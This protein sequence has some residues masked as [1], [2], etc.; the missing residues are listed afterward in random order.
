[1][2]SEEKLVDYLR[3]VTT[4]LHETRR[5]LRE[6]EERDAEPVAV[7]AMAC[8]FPGGVRSP[9]E[10]WSLVASGGD[11]IGEFPANRGW[12]TGRLFH[13]D[14]GHPGTSIAR[15]GG[16]LEDA[17]LFDSEFFGIS[18]REALTL[19]PQQRQL[20]EVSW[21]LLERAGIDPASL[22]GSRTGVYA[23][24]A[25]P[26]FGT[27]HID[28]SAEGYLITGNAPSVLS[29]RVAY[30]L[31]L[32]GPAVTIDTA[33][34]SSLV[35]IHLA[36]H[37]L[38][39]NECTLALAG[40]VTVMALPNVFTEFSRQRG[41]APDGR[42]KAFAAAADGTGFS[43]GVGLVLLERLSDARRG[44]HDVLALIR[45][46]AINS[47]GA[48]NGLTAPN[49][50]SQQR[51]IRQALESARLSAADVDAV[52]A[53]G[54]GTRL[55]DPIEA[56]ALLA[57]YGR[58]REDDHPL[59]LGTVKSNLGHTQGA[60]GVA[61]LLKMVMALRHELLPATL[62]VDRPTPDVDWDSGAV[63]LL[64]E[65]VP[66]PS[67][68][69]PRRAAVSSFGIS[70]TNA[71]LI[72]EEPPCPEP[73]PGPERVP[74]AAGGVAWPLSART[75]QALTAQAEALA[76]HLAAHPEAA[77]TD[78]SWSL[79]R[80]RT[81]FEHRAVL[82]G[83]DREELCAALT[84][85][86]AGARRHPGLT[87][88]TGPVRDGD[89]VFLFTG[90][91]SQRSGM[92]QELYREYPAFAEAFDEVCAHLDP[93]LGRSLRDLVFGADTVGELGQ[94]AVTQAALFALE[95]AL[96]RLATSAGLVPGYLTGHSVGE[97]TA[98]HAA[99]V[100]SLPDACT[101]VAARGSLMQALPRGGAMVAVQA[102][103]CDVLP[104]LAGREDR[105]SLAAVN[106]PAAVVVSGVEH[107]VEEIAARLRNMGHKARRLR[108]SHAF[109]SPLL[110]PML[111]EFGEVA[112]GLSY[113][114]PRI[115]VISNL[116][117][118]VAGLEQLGDPGYWVRHV[119]Q[120]VR[121]ADGLCTLHAAG[122]IRYL[123]LG[124]APVLTA[125][126]RECLAAEEPAPDAGVF[127][128]VLRENH[129]ETRTFLR[130]LAS[131][132]VDGAMV[133]FAATLPPGARAVPLP[134]YRFQRRH[135]WR[136]IAD[137]AVVNAAGVRAADHP[138]LAAAIESAT[139]ELLF[140]GHLSV[141]AH[142]WL[143]DHDIAGAVPLPATAFLELA[144]AA[145]R[146]AGCDL[147]ED[148]TLEAP[149]ILPPSGGVDV[150]V[151]VAVPDEAGRRP[152]VIHSRRSD[153]ADEETSP[154]DAWVRH[155]AGTFA[156]QAGP[157][158]PA[159]PAAW[160]PPAAAEI[161]VGELYA[162]L[163]RHGYRY[164]VAF[165]GVHTAWRLGDDLF[166][167]VRPVP[168]RHGDAR[169]YV[170]HPAL[171]DSALHAI[172]ELYSDDS[173]D[174]RTVRLPFTFGGVRV[175]TPGQSRL[176]VQ[177]TAVGADS[178]TLSLTDPD[179]NPAVTIDTLG[180]RAVAADRWRSAYTA[181]PAADDA[182]YR[183]AWQPPHTAAAPAAPAAQAGRLAVVGP[184]ELGLADVLVHPDLAALR[185]SIAAGHLAPDLVIVPCQGAA[186]GEDL[187]ARV[188]DVTGQALAVLQEWLS[189]ERLAAGRLVIATRGAVAAEPPDPVTASVWGLVRAAQAEHPDR[190]ALLD[191]D[192][193][194]TPGA[195]RAAIA[196]AEPQAAVRA[197]KLLVPRLTRARVGDATACP[198]NR[199]GTV[200]I[201][202]GTGAL[203][204]LVARHLATAHGM[205]HL[206]LVSRRGG[207]AGAEE[208]LVGLDADVRAAACDVAD[209]RALS[210]LLAS[211]PSEHPLTA[212]IHAAGIVDDGVVTSLTPGKLDAVF[213]PKLDG[214][215]HLHRLTRHHDLAAF[216]LFSSAA[217]VLGSAGQGNYAAASMFLD[218]L[219]EHRRAE[220]LPGTSLA[221][222]PW[223]ANGG[224]ADAL[225]GNDAARIVRSGV[226]PMPPEQGLAL[227]DVA[228]SA[229]EPTLVPVK[230]D[231]AALRG[232][233]TAGSLSPVLRSLAHA[234][235]RPVS[236]PWPERLAALPEAERDPVVRA[237]VRDQVAAVLSHPEPE[238]IDLSRAFQDLGFD[239]LTAL[240]LRNGF[241]AAT[242]ISLPSTAIFDYPTPEA[243]VRYLRA[244]L[245]GE[246]VGR[247]APVPVRTVPDD[248]IAIVGMACRY[249]GGAGSPEELWGLV[250]GGVDAVGEFPSNREWDLAEL[251]DPDP[252]R[253]GR[254]YVRAGGFLHDA[255]LFDA[256]FF[257]ISPREAVAMDP[258]QRLLLETAW[259][260]LERAGID[261]A[262]LR[263][264]ETGV[265]VG[266]MY[267]DYGSRFLGRIPAE[268]EGRLMPG[269]LPSVVSGRLAYTFGLEGP[270]VTVDTACSSSLVAMHL[271][272]QSLRQ[273]ECPLALAGGV[274]V[275]ATPN[276]FVEF[277][278]QRGLSPD[279]RC[280]AFAAAADG[281][282][283]AEGVGVVVLERLSDARCNGHQVLAIIRGSAVNSDG[284]SNGLTAPN[285]P[286]Q[287]RVI[288]A[289]LVAA[290]ANAIDVD[291]VEAHGTGTTLGDPIEANALLATYGQGRPD[292]RPLWL[293]TVKSNIGHTQAAAGVAGVIKM[294]M[295]MRHGV[296]PATL[297]VDEPTPHV[298]WDSGAV[299]LLT[300]PVPWPR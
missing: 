159:G 282:G 232:Q 19:D 210:A 245:S 173:H 52:E 242:G 62:H 243:L 134:V 192:E 94:T 53:H 197:G 111:E 133:D 107:D 227:F 259:Q 211:V 251:F 26:G 280:K 201:T 248:P 126:A 272:A 13:P 104:M 180:L 175:H 108:V 186:G 12:D 69:L 5:R 121:F 257:G 30:T 230:L 14:P 22:K 106:G 229:A 15:E 71:H 131:L 124:P 266:V 276:T 214:A 146:E 295:A 135:Y 128:A 167:D 291:A 92:G 9:E 292:G 205:R 11:V 215:W 84:A 130:A 25:L 261:P 217:G 300:E 37:A 198:L 64:T 99:G 188:R 269:S 187:P 249:P 293:G 193:Q 39:R 179:G 204:R 21:E 231:R 4:D 202:G 273:G 138:L 195:L 16:F 255:D 125:M 219:A 47:D 191:L 298:D 274:T 77:I 7:V 102:A 254:S 156:A 17:G 237:L 185:A 112:R 294:V 233:A 117:G 70:G 98:A 170:V 246:A 8:R 48:S 267:D 212:V 218:A 203:G 63:R 253:V 113:S 55:G 139:G 32:E 116:T 239:S 258:Q 163:A 123:E 189:D 290:G 153:L 145:A 225:A 226:V 265:Y 50:P 236:T 168:E 223:A 166:A 91:G 228:L 68:A 114:A 129:P 105:V 151:S 271:A 136:P 247:P 289:A 250:A 41:L 279:G 144:L 132:Y 152:V 157:P 43:E 286:A 86:A 200:L 256:A 74:R 213:A 141:R 208:E 147:I 96:F 72:L 45:G 169:D 268:V 161:D 178:F 263:G 76:A 40:G 296:L 154:R 137:A 196:A 44:S 87:R 216:V 244:Q 80:T 81:S 158:P 49:G 222:G 28:R 101:L 78:V 29:G 275:M 238:A 270:A 142:A 262:A 260:A 115:P 283:W 221:W 89:T 118:E 155:A 122:V 183:V 20:L 165:R 54:T 171:L 176:R 127:A 207:T 172:D 206:L 103:E 58:D 199:D 95:V 284:A 209:P 281:T 65:P 2:V 38:R 33:C 264:S 143:A 6:T 174:G 3:R 100:L 82:F 88:S 85:L 148:L 109:H 34:S 42:C 120:P 224:M 31:G 59:W 160:P 27:P 10:L 83:A 182:L 97:L 177:I 24:T 61:G 18:P 57:T 35:A 297:H 140:T 36:C 235:A 73:A 110:D 184:D 46:S 287:E 51:V 220:G 252:D 67:G 277:S 60:A 288:R 234:R 240:E 66:W 194:T 278:R 150:Q 181:Y 93:L 90:Q 164:G 79:A 149:L 190:I 56:R 285:G 119:R 241:A 1:M 75:H 23:G 299:R 162:R